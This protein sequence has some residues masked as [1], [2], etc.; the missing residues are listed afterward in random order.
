MVRDGVAAFPDAVTTRGKKHLVE[1]QNLV[2]SNIRCVMFYLIQRTDAE[3]FRPADEI[4]REYGEE[5]R[6]AYKNG[7]EILAYDVS[8]D[9]TRIGVKRKIPFQL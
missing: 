6:K 8:I 3:L 5:L 7:I 4:D 1:L 2:D 9:E